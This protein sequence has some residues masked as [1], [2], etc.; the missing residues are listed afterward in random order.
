MKNFLIVFLLIP[1]IS[2]A[3]SISCDDLL[4]AIE[5]DGDKLGYSSVYDSS[6]ISNIDWYEYDDKLFA[7]VTF[8][9]S[10]KKYI[11]GGWNYD[12]YDYYDFKSSFEDAD[13]KG[14]FFHRNIRNATVDCY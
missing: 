5:Y 14:S 12:S 3:Q 6:A 9:S 7:L 11:Y 10:Y 8:T 2:L 4:E 13:S 1:F